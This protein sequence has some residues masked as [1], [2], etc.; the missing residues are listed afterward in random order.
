MKK[1]NPIYSK[2]EVIHGLAQFL[3]LVARIEAQRLNAEQFVDNKE[4]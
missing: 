1:S 4:K 3:E 2:F